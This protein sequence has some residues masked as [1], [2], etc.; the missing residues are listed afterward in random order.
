LFFLLFLFLL[1]FATTQR[2]CFG[3]F[4]SSLVFLTFIL[5]HWVLRR[6]I[7]VLWQVR[8]VARPSFW[9]L[10]TI[11]LGR[12]L[13]VWIPRL[14]GCSERPYQFTSSRD[15]HFSSRW[16]RQRLWARCVSLL[17]SDSCLFHTIIGK[18]LSFRREYRL[19]KRGPGSFKMEG[20]WRIPFLFGYICSLR[21]FSD[22][23]K[24]LGLCCFV[25]LYFYL[26]VSG[27][28]PLFSDAIGR[29][30]PQSYGYPVTGVLSG[31]AVP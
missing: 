20:G 7:S 4:S 30:G 19:R 23:G 8:F 3:V 26:H 11:Y 14:Y 18:S 6:L 2:V 13:R 1:L 22:V 28:A 25:C 12:L 29:G 24:L 9:P 16:K 31:R 5:R 10:F 21:G 15:G 27:Q 17:L